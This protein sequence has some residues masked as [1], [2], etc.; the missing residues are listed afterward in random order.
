MLETV[1]LTKQYD[2]GVL[3]VDHLNLKVQPGEIFTMLGANGAGK[4]TTINMQHD[5]KFHFS[6]R[7]TRIGQRH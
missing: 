7:W 5:S 1:D 3:A 4:T 2:N 6:Y